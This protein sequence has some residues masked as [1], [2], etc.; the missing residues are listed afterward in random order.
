MS[1]APEVDDFKRIVDSLK[2]ALALVDAKGSLLYANP[3]FAEAAGLD[4]APLESF[5]DA[6]VEGDRKRITQSVARVAE[7]KAASGT[8]E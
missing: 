8:V 2:V 5:A 1:S 7:R 6:F 4:Q 3:A